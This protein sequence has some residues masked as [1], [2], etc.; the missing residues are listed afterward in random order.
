[1]A[2]GQSPKYVK[3]AEKL[4]KAI[5][6]GLYVAGDQLPAETR[7]AEEYRVTVPTLRRAMDILRSQNLVQSRQGVGTFVR[8]LSSSQFVEQ[9]FGLA[10]GAEIERTTDERPWPRHIRSLVD[11]E[12]SDIRCVAMFELSSFT[13]SSVAKGTM[14]RVVYVPQSDPLLREGEDAFD[15]ILRGAPSGAQVFTIARPTDGLEGEL[16]GLAPGA[17]VLSTLKSLGHSRVL[18]TVFPGDT[19]VPNFE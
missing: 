12:G 5:E 17:P 15:A 11:V 6:S 2:Q 4:T 13:D 9:S 19:L 10:S 3:I 1:M 16:L 18:D 7:L 14:L 8:S